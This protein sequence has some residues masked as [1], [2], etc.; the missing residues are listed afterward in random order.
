MVQLLD[1]ARPRAE[2]QPPTDAVASHGGAP[3]V[4][5]RPGARFV[6]IA[7]VLAGVTATLVSR[8]LTA[9]P[10]PPVLVGLPDAG[11]FTRAGLPVAQFVQELAGIAVVGVLFVRCLTATR[12]PDPAG[13]HLRRVALRW[14]WVWLAGATALSLLTLSELAGVPAAEV[15]SRP[16]LMRALIGTDRFMAGAVT[17]WV[18]LL[19]VLFVERVSGAL[20]TWLLAVAAAGA[21]LPGALTGHAAHH[22]NAIVVSAL[23]LGVHIVAAGVWIGGLLALVVHLRKFP[24]QLRRAIP[25][26]SAAALVCVAAVGASGL[27]AGILMLDG[28]E[29]LWTSPRGHLI[30]AKTVALVLLVVIGHLHRRRTLAAACSG[31]LG[32]L[33]RLGA[34]ELSLMGATLGVAVVLSTTA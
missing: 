7:M 14:A 3:Q 20:G 10:V 25:R 21:L 29:A 1:S 23:S 31:R 16:E 17:L 33:I 24:E 30:L 8:W 15:L 13:P 22:D 4:G 19:L 5:R 9:P 6:V 18:A 28:W 11:A 12:H 27:L 2:V 34:V 26:F 32:P